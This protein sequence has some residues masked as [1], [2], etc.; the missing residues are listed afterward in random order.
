MTAMTAVTAMTAMTSQGD[1]KTYLESDK[2]E[3]GVGVRESVDGHVCIKDQ[4]EN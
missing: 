4:R 3:S 1:I 2:S